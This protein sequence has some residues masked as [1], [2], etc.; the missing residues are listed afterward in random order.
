[1][2]L[3]GRKKPQGTPMKELSGFDGKRLSYVVERRGADEQVIGRE[4]GITVDETGG[5]L[6]IVCNGTPVADMKLEGLVCA[7]L[8]SRNGCDIKG[9][10]TTG[11]RR[12]LVAHYSSLRD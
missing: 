5:K 7:E 11:V 2:G 3:F 9:T 10:D 4:G 8:M 1:M 12:H 6:T